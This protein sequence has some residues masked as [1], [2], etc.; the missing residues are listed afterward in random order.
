MNR[1]LL[2]IMIA[3]LMPLIVMAQATIDKSNGTVTKDGKT[4]PLYG[5]VQIVN[6]FPDLKVQIVDAFPDLKVQVV[7]SFPDKIG[8]VQVVNSFPDVKV[9]I[10]NSFPDIKVKI[11]DSF[12]GF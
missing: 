4:F 6:S 1:R 2:T 3:V 8:K 12:P 9:Q 11:V 7:N 10:V 5:K